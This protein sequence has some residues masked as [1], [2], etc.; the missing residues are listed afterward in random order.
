MQT[1]LARCAGR[2]ATAILILIPALAFAAQPAASD[3]ERANRPDLS[4]GGEMVYGGPADA[5]AKTIT[6][7]T[8]V[9]GPWGSGAAFNGQFQNT[10]GGPDWNGWTSV[11]LT[12]STDSHWHADTV[13]ALA[14]SWSAWC[15]TVAYGSCEPGDPEGGYGNNWDEVLEWRGTVADPEVSCTVT[16]AATLQSDTEPGYDYAYLSVV[17]AGAVLDLLSFDDTQAAAPVNQQT[18]YTPAD[19]EGA[20]ADQVVVQFRFDSDGGWSDED[21]WWTTDGAFRVDDLAITLSNGSGYSHDFEDGTLGDLM[22]LLPQGVGNFAQIWTNLGTT[23]TC[24]RRNTSPMVAFI[25][26]GIVVPGTGGTPCITW[27]YGPGGFIV[28]TTGGLAGPEAHIHNAIESPVMAWPGPN[29]EGARLEFDVWEDL[30]FVSQAPGIF[31][32]WHV[33]STVEA[34]PAAIGAMPWQ[35]RNIFHYGGPNWRRHVQVVGDLIPADAQWVQIQ[36]ACIEFG[37]QWDIRGNDGSPSPYF[38][39]VRLTAYPHHGPELVARVVDLPHDTFPEGGTLDLV[40][41]GANNI[42]FD[43]GSDINRYQWNDALGNDPGD[44][45]LVRVTPQRAGATLVG[46]PRLHWSL[47]RNPLFDAYR[48]SGLPDQG[49]IE[50]WNALNSN[51]VPVPDLFAFDLPDTGF[52]FPGD[53][54]YYYFSATDEVGGEQQTALLPADTTGFSN[55]DDPMAWL[56]IYKLHALP[57]LTEVAG[58]PGTI[59]QPAILFW[60]DAGAVGNRDEWYM[61]YRNLGLVAGVDYDIYYTNAPSSGTGNGLGGRSTAVQL[62]G[63]SELIYTSG[64]QTAFTIVD[65]DPSNGDFSLD[66]QVLTA[67]LEQGGKDMLLTGDDLAGDLTRRGGGTGRALLHDWMGVDLV[68]E[69]V[70]GLIDLQ[71]APLIRVVPGQPV[72]MTVDQWRGVANCLSQSTVYYGGGSTTT[73]NKRYDGV[74]S[75]AGAQRLAEFTDPSGA[76]GQYTFSAITLNERIDYDARVI[77]LPYDFQSVETAD[78]AKAAA[79]LAARVRLLED[80]LNYFGHSGGGEPSGVPAADVFTAGSHPNPF[81]PATIISWSLP[82]AGHLGVQVY[83]VRGRLVR[84]L[85]DG[86]TA[87]GPGDVRW[88]GRAD[89]GQNAAAGVY[90]W[91]VKAGADTL[92]GKMALI[93]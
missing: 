72:F 62:A 67:W 7:S 15:G 75:R 11:D 90:F 47:K 10:S 29:H 6:D 57:T 31:Y 24:V 48:S 80:V 19:Y 26:D 78:D 42:R 36:L 68:D 22:P 44:S 9:M 60:D 81:N 41:L 13:G 91:R 14:G 8:L 49:S 21:C 83:D 4:A 17:K 92:V 43:S 2:F 73:G 85:V 76:Q 25:D 66:S 54:L 70:L 56:P 63:Y 38:D 52:L 3:A 45:V 82:Q 64:V 50:G 34:D 20:A 12:Q 37:W 23:D 32:S 1:R 35:N 88:D 16:I 33:R 87:A 69:N 74:A 55:F 89:G 79:G 51:G 27:C 53:F 71:T 61:A 58:Q 59:T 84:T 65:G 30:P 28:N 77:S 18:V 93:K 40:D 46:V 86:P 39:N 5:A